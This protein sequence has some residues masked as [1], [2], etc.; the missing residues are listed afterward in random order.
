[1]SQV[2]LKRA[3]GLPLLTLYG[4]GT[5]LGAGIYVLIGEVAGAAGMAAPSAFLI[6][7]VVASLTALSY[8]ELSSRL[9]KSAGEAAY[10]DAGFQ[11]PW[12]SRAV[13]WAVIATGIVSAA[14][15][16]RGLVGYLTVFVDIP[17]FLVI[18]VVVGALTAI[19][20]WGVTESLWAAAIVTIL[21]IAGLVFVCVV[22]GDSLG[23]LP[24]EWPNLMP[25]SGASSLAGV[26]AGAFLAFYAFIGFEDIVNVA[27]EVRSPATSLPTAIILSLVI[28]AI[29]CCA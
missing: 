23:R 15:M 7:C 12:L 29:A 28:S 4:L 18:I 9:P 26:F 17:S 10:V 27:E 5:I 3:I 11:R 2:T 24:T 25:S 14:T 8:A 1:M 19:A 6:A 16:C 13:G 21:E 20:V 22:A